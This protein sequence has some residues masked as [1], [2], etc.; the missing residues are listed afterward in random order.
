[1]GSLG[2][3][4][5][6]HHYKVVQVQMIVACVVTVACVSVHMYNGSSTAWRS[7]STANPMVD[8]VLQ[9]HSDR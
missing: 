4:K 2:R 8:C 3:I 1:M 5:R 7:A 6:G 9:L